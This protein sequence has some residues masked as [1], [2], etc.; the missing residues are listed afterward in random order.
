MPPSPKLLD[1]RPDRSL[2]N[3][4]F[5]GYKLSLREISTLTTELGSPVD[6]LFPNSSQYSL[7]HAKLFGLHNHLTGET[8]EDTEAVYFFDTNWN[9]QEFK[10]DGD[11]VSVWELPMLKSR[12]PGDYNV[13]IKL[14]SRV[15]ALVADGVGTLYILQRGL[16]W[17]IEFS[18]EIAGPNQ[19]FI[20]IDGTLKSETEMHILL[21]NIR[22]K[23]ESERFC[24]ILHWMTL[25]KN[26]DGWNQVA[27]RELTVPG[28][29]QFANFEESCT[30]L[31]VI[32]DAGCKFTLDSENIISVSPP[33]ERENKYTWS[34]SN[35]ELKIKIPSKNDLLKDSIQITSEHKKI[36]VKFGDEVQMEGDLYQTV[37]SDMTTWSFEPDAVE[38]VLSKS[39][40]GLM[41]PE[42][43]LG[44]HS[45]EYVVDP[46]VAEEIAERLAPLT[47]EHEVGLKSGQGLCRP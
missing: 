40:K 42:L 4:D 47:S 1:L 28:F 33:P 24:S 9:L 39:R 16:K 43:I 45:G 22:H 11:L 44:D 21:L 20:I 14:I 19:N 35:D 41:W 2:L 3:S 13:S 37:D 36:L 7:L 31:Y 26:D 17:I 23:E 34:Q 30:A 10:A 32:S 25:T 18:D 27:L 12:E 38:I 8:Y 46:I 5:P 6:R 15:T 29:V